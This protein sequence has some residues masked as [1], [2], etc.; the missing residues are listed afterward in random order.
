M[1]QDNEQNTLKRCT[2]WIQERV[3]DGDV[4]FKK[5]FQVCRIGILLTM[6]PT[7][8][9]S[10]G[11]SGAKLCQSDPKTQVIPTSTVT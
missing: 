8:S 2:L 7:L 10:F 11:R 3:Q 6:D 4:S 1:E 9:T 5:V